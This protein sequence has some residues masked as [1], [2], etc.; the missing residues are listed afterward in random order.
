MFFIISDFLIVGPVLPNKVEVL[1]NS[2]FATVLQVPST[3]L[4]FIGFNMNKAPF[5]DVNVRKVVSIMINK[6]EII[7]GVH[8][9]FGTVA[10][11][12][13]ASKVFG[14]SEDIKGIEKDVE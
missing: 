10:E 3:T 5:N 12:P 4:S 14:D 7:D 9:G 13:I 8:E 1:K 11:G 2:D 6:Q